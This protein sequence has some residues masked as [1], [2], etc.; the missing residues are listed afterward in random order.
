MDQP[1]LPASKRVAE[2]TDVLEVIFEHLGLTRLPTLKCVCTSWWALAREM[3]ARWA[4]AT[5]AGQVNPEL[6]LGGLDAPYAVRLPDDG[7]LAVTDAANACILLFSPS[8]LDG[9]GAAFRII[10]CRGASPGDLKKPKGLATD[11]TH[12]FVADSDNHRVQQLRISD[13][14]SVDSIGKQGFGHGHLLFPEGLALV[15]GSE[16]DGSNGALPSDR[17][18]AVGNIDRL[19]VADCYNNR[20][21]VFGVSPLRYLT[22]I[23]KRGSAPLEFNFPKG[24]AVH[25]GYLYVADCEN[26]RVQV[27]TF[28]GGFVRSFRL[29]YLPASIA[30]RP[31]GRFLIRRGTRSYATRSCVELRTLHGSLLQVR[32]AKYTLGT[33]YS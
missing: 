19:Y 31:D 1:E 11:G 29:D 28:G 13:G 6:I 12:L 7:G 3:R 25:A 20:I 30:V 16:H 8:D 26:Q 33:A 4:T 9:T 2:N 21:C 27:L 10:G 5:I 22:S 15:R 18:L 32:L 17:E 14:R 23:G 24:V